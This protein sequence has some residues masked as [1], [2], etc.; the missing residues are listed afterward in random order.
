MNTR[1]TSTSLKASRFYGEYNKTMATTLKILIID[2]IQSVRDALRAYLCPAPSAADSLKALL[3]QGESDLPTFWINEADQGEEG[4]ALAQVAVATNK[5]Y[6]IIFV[7]M[8]MP[9]GIGG[10]EVIRRIR[11]FD[12]AVPII[13]CTAIAHDLPQTLAQ[14]NGG[15]MPFLLAKPVTIAQNLPELVCRLTKQKALD[16]D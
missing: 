14:A 12:A 6:D 7:D 11:E 1:L 15:T 10:V 9:P 13:A 2:D 3:N 5:P 16:N 8:L 4:V